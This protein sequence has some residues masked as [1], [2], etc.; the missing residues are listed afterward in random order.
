VCS[1]TIVRTFGMAVLVTGILT[2]LRLNPQ[3]WA[4]IEIDMA[5]LPE[6]SLADAITVLSRTPATLNALLRGLPNVWVR[7][8]EG[9]DTWNAFDIVGHLI[10]G[11]RTDWIPRVGIMLRTARRGHLIPL[12]ILHS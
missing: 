2:R 7:G 3:G 5:N 9:K 1:G 12:T 6:F 8:N 10:S 4:C 11:D